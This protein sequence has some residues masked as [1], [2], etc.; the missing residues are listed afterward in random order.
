MARS[1][2]AIC[3]PVKVEEVRQRVLKDQ[4][5]EGGSTEPEEAPAR[6]RGPTISRPTS[7]K[8]RLKPGEA[9]KDL[10]ETW[11]KATT[12]R[13]TADSTDTPA[14]DR[15]PRGRAAPGVPRAVP[16]LPENPGQ[17][18]RKTLREAHHFAQRD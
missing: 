10:S 4:L 7:Q 16:S 17:T 1:V 18:R 6:R 8:P 14:A 3:N 15:A 11:Q 9:L 5:G 13:R 2:W 12:R